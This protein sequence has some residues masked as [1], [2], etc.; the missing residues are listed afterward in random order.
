MYPKAMFWPQCD[1]PSCLGRSPKHDSVGHFRPRGQTY[2]GIDGAR[3]AC[4]VNRT[5][6][7]VATTCWLVLVDAT[8]GQIIGQVEIYRAQPH[9]AETLG[10]AYSP[11]GK[12]IATGSWDGAVRIW[13]AKNLTKL[14]VHQVPVTRSA[15]NSAHIESVS[16]SPDGDW[17]AVTCPDGRLHLWSRGTGARADPGGKPIKAQISPKSKKVGPTTGP[18]TKTG[19]TEAPE[20]VLLLGENDLPRSIA[21]DPLGAL[22]IRRRIQNQVLGPD[23]RQ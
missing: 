8:T 21:W 14:R 9:K 17:L 12:M 16:F 6:P 7:S 2:V 5:A 11:D 13:N 15:P 4:A 23:D 10:L 3:I 22:D 20:K 18:A 19:W 1:K